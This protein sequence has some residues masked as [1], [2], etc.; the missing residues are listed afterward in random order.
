MR[1]NDRQSRFLAR[2][3]VMN[4]LPLLAYFLCIIIGAI[5]LVF[6]GGLMFCIAC[7]PIWMTIVGAVAVVVGI[8]AIATRGQ[9]AV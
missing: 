8:A 3:N 6:P 7:G 1:V 2:G 4:N 9:M 5:M